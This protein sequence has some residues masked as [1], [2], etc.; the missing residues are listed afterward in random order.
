MADRIEIECAWAKHGLLAPFEQLY[1]VY[2][3]LCNNHEKVVDMNLEKLSKGRRNDKHKL[4][5]CFA[6]SVDNSSYCLGLNCM[7]R[8]STL[9]VQAL[10][11]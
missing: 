1:E 2:Y 9:Y 4:K 3:E 8:S 11:I 5:D 6:V 10:H 7:W